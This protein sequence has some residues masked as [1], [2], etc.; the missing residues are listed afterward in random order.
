MQTA[1][2]NPVRVRNIAQEMADLARERGE[3]LTKDEYMRQG[4]TEE[5]IARHAHDASVLYAQ[6]LN[7]VAA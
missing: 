2:Y 1:A 3:G 4:F 6:S 5:Q 7:R